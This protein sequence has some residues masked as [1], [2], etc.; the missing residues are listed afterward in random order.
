ML[1][2]EAALKQLSR[3]IINSGKKPHAS[4]CWTLSLMML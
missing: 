3:C 1:N 2:A 4:Q